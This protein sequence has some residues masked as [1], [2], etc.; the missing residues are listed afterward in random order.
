[1]NS[2]ISLECKDHPKNNSDLGAVSRQSAGKVKR[3]DVV[4]S[5]V[6]TLGEVGLM[7]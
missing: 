4:T 3:A 6:P 7:T 5:I 1:M 2:S